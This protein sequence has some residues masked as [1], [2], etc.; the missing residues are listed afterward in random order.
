M[1]KRRFF[2]LILCC[3]LFVSLFGAAAP[4][5]KAEQAPETAQT[6][7]SEAVK[8]GGYLLPSDMMLYADTALL[9][10]L[11]SDA[12]RDVV[13]YEKAADEVRAPG[14]MMRFMVVAYTLHTLEK[15]G[16]DMDAV[17]GSYS[18]ELFNKYVAG[19]DVPTA[20]MQY[21]ETWTLRDLLTVSF[22]Q[23][24]SDAVTTLACTLDGDVNT[25][26]DGMN[27]L[28]QEIGCDYTHF[29]N[30][31]GLDSLSQYTTARDMYRIIRYAQGFSL[32]EEIVST[33]QYTVKPVAVGTERLLVSINSMQ[34]SSSQFYYSPLAFGRTGLSEHEGRTCAS[35]ARDGGY[36]YLVVVMGV[37]DKNEAG[38][39]GLHFRDTRELFRWAFRSFEHATILTK[40]EILASVQVDLAWN[41][42]HVNLIPEREF[43]T[44]VEKSL[45]PEQIIR[46]RVVYKNAVQAPVKKGTVLGKVE[47]IINVD[48]KIGEVNLVAAEDVERSQL[49]H[50]WRGFKG[51]F[52]SPWFWLG[53]GILLVLIIGY[54]ILNI[55][56]NRRRRRNRLQRVKSRY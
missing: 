42:D 38:E 13:L 51:F 48:Q 21:G 33:R 47:L 45:D 4:C 43:S 5:A 9:I 15:T 6:P 52:T 53:L 31:T 22:M 8:T 1:L 7:A 26:V 10:N 39:G 23:N 54:I 11:G 24:A 49:L 30:V 29:A 32:F 41:T 3:I 46:N 55:L 20:N 37:P 17:T 25:F 19:T 28:A 12:S 36:E 35:V 2:S 50:A 56:Y 40:S 44:V 27:A 16:M 18:V 34:Q 14:A